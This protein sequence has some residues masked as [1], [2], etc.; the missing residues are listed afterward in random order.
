VLFLRLRNAEIFKASNIR[1]E[2][3]AIFPLASL[4]RYRGGSER[5]AYRNGL[6]FDRTRSMMCARTDTRTRG[7]VARATPGGG[8]PRGRAQFHFIV[9]R[10]LSSRPAAVSA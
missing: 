7:R 8:I 10:S 9:N 5:A 4:R 2:R 1:D 3:R 6:N